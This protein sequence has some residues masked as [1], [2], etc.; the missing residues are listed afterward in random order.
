MMAVGAVYIKGF[1]MPKTKQNQI[2]ALRL[3]VSPNK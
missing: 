1:T 3:C 2:F